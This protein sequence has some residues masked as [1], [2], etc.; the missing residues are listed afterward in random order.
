MKTNNLLFCLFSCCMLAL[1]SFMYGGEEESKLGKTTSIKD[2][3]LEAMF[4]IS[5]YW[6]EK[7][8]TDVGLAPKSKEHSRTMVA[9]DLAS[10]LFVNASS[11]L[12]TKNSTRPILYI[13]DYLFCDGVFAF[14]NDQWRPATGPSLLYPSFTYKDIAQ[15]DKELY[16]EAYS[17][18]HLDKDSFVDEEGCPPAW[19]SPDATYSPEGDRLHRTHFGYT[20]FRDRAQLKHC[21][22]YYD[23]LKGVKDK[24]DNESIK[25]ALEHGKKAELEQNKK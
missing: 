12:T 24:F 15:Y 5:D 23:F 16:S 6:Y 8:E 11:S 3:P 2:L 4:I 10:W 20:K 7:R 13:Y 25:A 22:K 1:S 18:A 9:F 14:K 19:W 17:L 21:Q